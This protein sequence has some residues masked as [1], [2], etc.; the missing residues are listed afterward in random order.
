MADAESA[1]GGAVEEV[2]A[3]VVSVP[4]FVVLFA[5]W[6]AEPLLPVRTRNEDVSSSWDGAGAMAGREESAAPEAAAEADSVLL[7]VGS[8]PSIS[9]A[10]LDFRERL[11]RSWRSW[12]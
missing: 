4:L 8:S 10:A 7:F 1:G 12:G 2:A 9:R 6:P 11:I 5:A 3:G